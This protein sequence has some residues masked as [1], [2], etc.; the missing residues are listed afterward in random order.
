VGVVVSELRINGVRMTP[1]RARA[2]RAI[3][4][5]SLSTCR[6]TETGATHLDVSWVLLDVLERAGVARVEAAGRPSVLLAVAT[7]VGRRA[8][9]R[10]QAL[11]FHTERIVSVARR[12][13][14]RSFSAKDALVLL[15]AFGDRDAKPTAL[16]AVL[17]AISEEPFEPRSIV[18]VWGSGF[19]VTLGPRD[20]EPTVW[21]YAKTIPTPP[22]RLY[23]T[24]LEAIPTPEYL[25]R[26]Q[27]PTPA[28]WKYAL[29]FDGGL[30][31]FVDFAPHSRD[32]DDV[33]IAISTR[34][35]YVSM[36]PDVAVRTPR[37]ANLGQSWDICTKSTTKPTI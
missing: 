30:A 12:A 24:L 33:M 23:S 37:T 25:R 9:G 28:R 14:R 19:A 36:T 2:L 13:L 7:D 18:R 35:S 27:L 32:D 21:V 29:V 1:P 3:A 26:K 34:A 31:S 8:L 5:A 20:E 15:E 16:L 17:Q 4:E 10:L 6:V 11:Q 22:T